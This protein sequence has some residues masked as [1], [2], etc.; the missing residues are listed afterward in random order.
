MPIW[1]AFAE[2]FNGKG[3]DT[4]KVL[5]TGA[6]GF[7]GSYL[8]DELIANGHYVYGGAAPGSRLPET[9]VASWLYF[10]IT[11][12]TEL[13]DAL[14]RIQP[15]AIIH[16][17]AQSMVK[18]SWD[19]PA[20]TVLTNTIGTIN[21]LQAVKE[22]VPAAKVLTIG[23]GEEYGATGKMGAPLEETMPCLPQNPYAVS[24]MASGQLALQLAAKDGLRVV[25]ARPFNHFGPGQR[26]GFVVSDFSAQIAEIERGVQT[27]VIR[28]G[29]LSAQRDFTD[30]RDV[31][32][33]YRVLIESQCEN[34]IYN[35]CS[36]QPHTMQEILDYLVN[37][38][39]V[40]V[41]IEVDSARLRPADV[42]LF[43]GSANKLREK[44][45]WVPQFSFGESLL[46]TLNWWRRHVAN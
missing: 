5:V 8:I 30:V 33:A 32:A 38:A 21:L 10:D 15:D 16:L 26:K 9:A 27:P 36:G 28:V 41:N 29:N 2:N 42:P 12:A 43:V 13:E 44:T 35:I 24:K 25:H 1:N 45:G 6:N 46:D 23:T 20:G 31:V 19:D 17:A 11:H 14:A 34:G 39:Q 7:V 4:M 3:D 37:Q 22:V 18:Q 40:T